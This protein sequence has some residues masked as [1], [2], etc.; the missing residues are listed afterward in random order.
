MFCLFYALSLINTPTD[1]ALKTVHTNFV[2]S[3]YVFG[4]IP[5]GYM[6]VVITY[7]CAC[8]MMP[9]QVLNS[10]MGLAGVILSSRKTVYAHI[11]MSF[12]TIPIMVVYGVLLAGSIRD[13]HYG[14]DDT[15]NTRLN[16]GDSVTTELKG[17]LTC[18]GYSGDDPCQNVLITGVKLPGCWD[19]WSSSFKEFLS[20]MLA[21]VISMLILEVSEMWS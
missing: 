12:I 3:L 9:F 1:A 20:T 18:C 13:F 5:L 6:L 4:T 17:K 21:F 16:T 2:D 14:I 10:V 15:F 8:A 7:S 11:C 19:V